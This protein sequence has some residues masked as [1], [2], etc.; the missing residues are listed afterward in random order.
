MPNHNLSRLHV[1]SHLRAG[2]TCDRLDTNCVAQTPSGETLY[3]ADGTTVWSN[4]RIG[5]PFA[6]QLCWSQLTQTLRNDPTI[7]RKSS[8]H[9]C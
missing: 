9:Q 3:N 7:P 4:C 6:G 8:C 2:G 1:R 5:I